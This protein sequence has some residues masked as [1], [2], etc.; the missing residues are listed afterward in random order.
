MSHRYSKRGKRKFIPDD[1]MAA[2]EHFFES[3][4]PPSGYFST[5]RVKL[6]NGNPKPSKRLQF[7]SDDELFNRYVASFSRSRYIFFT[8]ATAS[9]I[10]TPTLR[11]SSGFSFTN[12]WPGRL[13][14][15]LMSWI[16]HSLSSSWATSL[17]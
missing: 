9:L 1:E 17:R 3:E 8:L 12:A 15:F 2:L 11:T 13:A 4:C 16:P 7:I 5:K 6:A 10:A 14:T